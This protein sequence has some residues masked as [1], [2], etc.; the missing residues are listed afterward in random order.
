MARAVPY[1]GLKFLI[2]IL[3]RV[4]SAASSA[5]AAWGFVGSLEYPLSSHLVRRRGTGAQG[6]SVALFDPRLCRLFV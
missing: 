5:G 2:E 1:F 6:T 3:E 4:Q